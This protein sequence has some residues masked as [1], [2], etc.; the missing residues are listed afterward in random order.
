MT[1]IVISKT[2]EHYEAS[3]YISKV[4]MVLSICNYMKFGA[5]YKQNEEHGNTQICNCESRSK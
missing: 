3:D 1:Y 5:V 2:T 4:R